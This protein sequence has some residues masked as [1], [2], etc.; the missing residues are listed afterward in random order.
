MK[1]NPILFLIIL[2]AICLGVAVTDLLIQE[3]KTGVQVVN[4][5][6]MLHIWGKLAVIGFVAILVWII[7]RYAIKGLF[8]KK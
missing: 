1:T 2:G 6:S 3:S 7:Y 8:K 5:W 4:S